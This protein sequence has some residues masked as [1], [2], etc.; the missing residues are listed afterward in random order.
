M[1][2]GA[3]QVVKSHQ[4]NCFIFEKLLARDTRDTS[5]FQI[6][7]TKLLYFYENFTS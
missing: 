5:N 6:T 1:I 7:S 2:I 4:Q 3:G